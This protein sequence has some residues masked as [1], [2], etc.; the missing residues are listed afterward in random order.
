VVDTGVDATHPDLQGQLLPGYDFLNDDANPAD[1]NGH[2]TRMIGI[3]GA[4]C[5]N[6]EASAVSRRG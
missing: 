3:V 1:D 6:A 4:L 5:D 2:G